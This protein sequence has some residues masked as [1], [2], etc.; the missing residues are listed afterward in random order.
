MKKKAFILAMAFLLSL[1]VASWALA[2]GSDSYE[3]SWNVIS[4][5]GDS[6][7]STSY[8]LEGSIGQLAI[9]AS[10]STSYG[11]EGGFWPGIEEWCRLYL[12]MVLKHH[13][14]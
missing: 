13:A 9:D 12:P 10:S 1:S 3:L 5:G 8:M 2:Q 6:M 4:G 14:P 7:I 11:L